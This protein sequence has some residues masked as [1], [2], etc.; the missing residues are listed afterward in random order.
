[1]NVL[2]SE[3]RKLT[4]TKAFYWNTA[5]FVL[6]P[7]VF[8]ALGVQMGDKALITPILVASGVAGV[9]FLIAIIQAI[10]VI[11]AEYRHN[12]ISVTFMATPRRWVV[13]LAKWLLTSVFFAAITFVTLVLCFLLADALAGS[14]VSINL[15]P[16]GE[17]ITRRIMWVYP[18]GVVGLVTLAQGF[19]WI[20]RQTAGAVALL[21][22]WYLA[23]ESLMSLLP[24]VGEW[25]TKF[26]PMTNFNSFINGSSPLLVEMPWGVPGSGYYFGAWA[27]GFFL[28]GLVLLRRRDA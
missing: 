22:M 8:T 7:L 28:L 6:L 9:S 19:T 14:E 23:L 4:T 24:K 13:A 18:V 27:I 1:M 11:S 5:L 17:E 12:Y 3:W 10:M 21:L 20:V 2:L 26:G 15:S 16:F 25:I